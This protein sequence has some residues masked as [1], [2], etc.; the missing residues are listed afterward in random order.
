[1]FTC[2][3]VLPVGPFAVPSGSFVAVVDGQYSNSSRDAFKSVRGCRAWLK[4]NQANHNGPLNYNNKSDMQVRAAACVVLAKAHHPL[5]AAPCGAQRA[6]L[7]SES[8]NV[9]QDTQTANAK[10]L[11]TLSALLERSVVMQQAD[12]G[13]QLTALLQEQQ[14]TMLSASLV[15]Q[16]CFGM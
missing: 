10:F 16:P 13:A 1:M 9:T 6:P 12:A 7:D 14:G 2:L 8:F 11:G 5:Q 4:M 15:D 3:T